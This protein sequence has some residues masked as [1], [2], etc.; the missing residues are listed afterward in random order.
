MLKQ[1][2]QSNAN[3]IARTKFMSMED[4]LPSFLPK[5]THTIPDIITSIEHPDLSDMC[6]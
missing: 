5:P 4:W 2:P 6:S 3:T 1:K